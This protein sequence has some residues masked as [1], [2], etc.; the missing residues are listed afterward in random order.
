MSDTDPPH[1]QPPGG[2]GDHWRSDDP[3]A[4]PGP[5]GPS[6][7]TQP[8]Y[9]PPPGYEEY[10][11]QPVQQASGPQP[12][13]HP[14]PYAGV[15]YGSQQHP[16]QPLRPTSVTAVVG[17]VLA[18]VV[19]P[20]GAVVSGFGIRDTR[21]GRRGG[22]GLAVAGVVIGA[23]GTVLWVLAVFAIVAFVQ[24]A[25]GTVAEVNR[26][27]EQLPAPSDLPSGL[28]SDLPSDFPT[29]L[30]SG[31][32]TDLSGL[33]GG[34]D[35]SGDVTVTSC[36]DALGGILTGDL[37]ITNSGDAAGSY[38]ISLTA[39]DASGEQV[40]QLA[41]FTESI[42]P[43]ATAQAQA[44]GYVDGDAQVTSCEVTTALRSEG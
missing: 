16:G 7:L 4:P 20:V 25:A 28:P 44:F 26:Q 1:R 39:L 27:I 29:D 24:A 36:T 8:L 10:A 5:P 14:G 12:G 21:G 42:D 22:R 13:Q 38:V 40:G 6:D 35:A 32:P 30:P 41:G 34:V 3:L 31:L 43:G 11:P 23:V 33:A 17:F 2:P 15:Q 18:F 19:S 9:T 37:S